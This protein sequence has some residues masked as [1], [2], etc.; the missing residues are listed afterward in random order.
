MLMPLF[1]FPKGQTEEAKFEPRL[2]SAECARYISS[3][4]VMDMVAPLSLK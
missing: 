1:G 4:T 2:W 3:T